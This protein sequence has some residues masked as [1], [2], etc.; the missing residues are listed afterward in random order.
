M[1]NIPA[2]L[3][4]LDILVQH[5]LD[6]GA[7]EVYNKIQ[8]TFDLKGPGWKPLHPI[9]YAIKKSRGRKDPSAIL[10]DSGL[11]RASIIIHPVDVASGVNF[12]RIGLFFEHAAADRVWIGDA[13]EYGKWIFIAPV[14]ANI[15]KMPGFLSLG[16]DKH[17]KS[18]F[19]IAPGE[20][21]AK[22]RQWLSK[23]QKLKSLQKA[24]R[25]GKWIKLPERS[26]IR[27]GMQVAIPNVINIFVDGIN[28][29]IALFT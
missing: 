9:T 28:G 11:M 16:R 29:L 14:P 3:S 6:L 10:I 4:S 8:R 24:L 26:F 7:A 19:I 18:R 15:T 5:L 1:N 23:A 17:G 13:H 27:K 20:N 2:F 22:L 25:K 12:R 21:E